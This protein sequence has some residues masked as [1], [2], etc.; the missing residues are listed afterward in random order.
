MEL[1]IGP[2]GVLKWNKEKA[3]NGYTVIAP[4][5][6]KT[7]YLI[8]MEGD[9]VHEWASE[10]LPGLYAELLPNGNLLRGV[11]RPEEVPTNYGGSSSGVQEIDWNGK[12]VWEYIIR[13]EMHAHHHCFK[14][15]PNGNTF[16]LCWEK[17][18]YEESLAKGRAPGTMEKYGY[19]YNGVNQRGLWPDYVIE[20]NKAGKIVW[21]WHCWDHV[22]TGVDELDINFRL[23]LPTGYLAQGDWTH[24]NTIDYCEKNDIVLLNSR[25]FG[26]FYFIDRKTGKIVY[27]WGNPSA[28]GKGREPSFA[29][30]GDQVL[31]GP[32]C[33]QFT[34]TG[35]V[36]LFDNGWLR[37]ELNRSRV[38]EMD[39]KTGDIVWEFLSNNPNSFSSPFQGATQRLPNGNTLVTSSNAGQIFEVNLAKEVV[40]VFVTPWAF[41]GVAKRVIIDGV[42]A[43]P[44]AQSAGIQ[45]N[46]VHRA[47]RYGTEFEGLKGKELKKIRRS[48]DAPYWFK[49]FEALTVKDQADAAEKAEK[50]AAAKAAAEAAK[51]A[52]AK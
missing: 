41:Q 9:I 47:Y 45:F 27:R 21:S 37:P 52:A 23:P 7:T 17:K 28:Y 8:D 5:F 25:N 1:L 36:V 43:M 49:E 35:T 39:P 38:I 40:W 26:E 31:F 33:P 16:I 24:Y 44:Q 50:V 2:T 11:R 6:T 15:A 29:D 19:T 10:D 30:D 34:E 13:D 42:D 22:G 12:V 32:H 51:A 48:V 20:V 14:R 4:S 18:S 3:F 46:M